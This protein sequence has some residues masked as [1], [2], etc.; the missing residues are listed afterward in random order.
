MNKP[1]KTKNPEWLIKITN[2]IP[3]WLGWIVNG[4][5]WVI[6]VATHNHILEF[7]MGIACIYVGIVAFAKRDS[8][9]AKRL[10]WASFADA[11]WMFRWAF[12]S[13]LELNF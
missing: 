4:M 1:E 13:P 2:P 6:F 5:A 7:I 12:W 8:S 3:L 11:I 10:M 9:N